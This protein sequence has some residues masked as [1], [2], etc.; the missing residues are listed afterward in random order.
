MT[1]QKPALGYRT[2]H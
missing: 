1:D 2:P